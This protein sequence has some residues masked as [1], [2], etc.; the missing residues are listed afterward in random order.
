MAAPPNRWESDDASVDRG[1][2]GPGRGR[3][4]GASWVV[5]AGLPASVLAA[6][7]GR[8][9]QRIEFQQQLEQLQQLQLQLEFKRQL[10]LQLFRRLLRLDALSRTGGQGVAPS[11]AAAAF[12]MHPIAVRDVPPPN[13]ILGG[14][15]RW[16]I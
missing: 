6:A 8:L 14:N 11:P 12:P 9:L 7:S 15:R 16:R 1:R 3:R 10:Q 5:S 13:P 2:A 4:L